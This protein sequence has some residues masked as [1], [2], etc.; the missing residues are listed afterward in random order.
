L[1]EFDPDNLLASYE[2]IPYSASHP[3]DN[4]ESPLQLDL[5]ERGWASAVKLVAYLTKVPRLLLKQRED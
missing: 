1:P 4:F 5:I 3:T 2:I